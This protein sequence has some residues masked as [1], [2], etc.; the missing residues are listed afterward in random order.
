[1]A[2]DRKISLLWPLF[3]QGMLRL[4]NLRVNPLRVVQYHVFV[5]GRALAPLRFSFANYIS[6]YRLDKLRYRYFLNFI[7]S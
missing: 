1:M 5:E 7:L 2:I 4:G 6:S 3:A